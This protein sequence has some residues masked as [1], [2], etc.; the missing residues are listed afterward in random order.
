MRPYPIIIMSFCN[1]RTQVNH[2]RNFYGV[3]LFPPALIGV[4][5]IF[6]NGVIRAG[7]KGAIRYVKSFFLRVF[8]RISPYICLFF[9]TFLWSA[10][11]STPCNRESRSI[12]IVRAF[13]SIIFTSFSMEKITGFNVFERSPPWCVRAMWMLLGVL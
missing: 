6:E 12:H 1:Q 7:G 10:V 9:F 4:R 2:F 5:L 3:A 8:S 13:N 11:C